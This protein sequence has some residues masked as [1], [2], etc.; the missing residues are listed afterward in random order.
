MTRRSAGHAIADAQRR[1]RTARVL[2]PERAPAG[3]SGG[4]TPPRR[5]VLVALAGAATFALLPRAQADPAA[6]RAAIDAF[7]GGA[8]PRAGGIVLDV[9][10]LVE[11]GNSV[12][13]AVRVDSPMTAASHV[14][15]I[16]LFNE[17]NPQPQVAVFHLGPRSGRA[18]VGTRMRMADSQR[19]VALAELSDGSFRQTA[20]DV[21]VTLAA[22]I[23]P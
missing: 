5:C 16:A 11:N 4:A 9:A 15:R 7:T 22:C 19:V 18:E 13:V 21:V 23:G 10:K 12:P 2:R 8:E 1:S 3:P 6:L 14:R 17:K 20:V